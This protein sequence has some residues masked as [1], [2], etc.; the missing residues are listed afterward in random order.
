M[1]YGGLIIL[2]DDVKLHLSNF[3]ANKR[4][5]ILSMS[6]VLW[7]L[8]GYLYPK[9]KYFYLSKN[10]VLSYIRDVFTL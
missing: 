10:E 6:E 7:Y 1:F 2:A 4:Y 9:A 3:E 8:T 5:P